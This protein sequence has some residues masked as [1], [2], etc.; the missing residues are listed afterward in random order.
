MS[1]KID[2]VVN[3]LEVL[4]DI[5]A[6]RVAD[7]LLMGSRAGWIDQG[8][9]PLGRRRHCSLVRRRIAELFMERVIGAEYGRD[10]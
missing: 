7:R 2:E 3:A 4:A 8:S 6:D 1:R 5:I 10:G 9:S